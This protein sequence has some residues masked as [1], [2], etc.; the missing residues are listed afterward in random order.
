MCVYR[1]PVPSRPLLPP[2]ADKTPVYAPRA[3]RALSADRLLRKW[4]LDAPTHPARGLSVRHHADWKGHPN[5]VEHLRIRFTMSKSNLD[6]IYYV[7]KLMMCN[8]YGFRELCCFVNAYKIFGVLKLV[9]SQCVQK[10]RNL[11]L[12]D[13]RHICT[14]IGPSAKRTRVPRKLAEYFHR[15]LSQAVR[16][17]LSRGMLQSE[18]EW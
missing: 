6:L 7:D 9:L 13:N 12:A 11:Y 2:S 8:E 18:V 5:M 15:I 3:T 4:N 1:D 16:V 10:M 14:I 17:D